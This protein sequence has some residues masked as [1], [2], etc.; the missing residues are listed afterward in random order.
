MKTPKGLTNLGRLLKKP[1][2][3]ASEARSVGVHPSLLT[4]YVKQGFIERIGRGVYR[5]K[6]AKM[7]VDF[8]WEDLVLSANSIPKGVVCLTSALALYELTEEIPRTHWIAIPNMYNAPKRE[9][10]KFIRMRNIRLGKS[11][12]TIGKEKVFIFDRER[13]LVDAFRHLS[14]ETAI[15][16]LKIGL[17][18]KGEK[19]VNLK[20]LQ[21]YAKK[22]RF[23]LDPYILTVTT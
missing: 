6:D 10:I 11:K 5:G 2:F 16:A 15:K 9:G 3:R 8:Q 21:T 4:Y 19:K 14:K 17:K 13:T 7:D 12:M 1:L 22:L 23:N 20:K 18:G